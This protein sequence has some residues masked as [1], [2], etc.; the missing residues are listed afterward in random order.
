MSKSHGVP[1]QGCHAAA[2]SGALGQ[3]LIAPLSTLPGLSAEL[4]QSFVARNY[5]PTRMVLAGSGIEHD[6]LVS[7]AEPMVAGLSGGHSQSSQTQPP[8]E[9]TGGDYRC[10][11]LFS[12]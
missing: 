3:P 6:A 11:F 2:Y 10:V 5:T 7:L 8:S 4:M 12:F 1:V 9:Y